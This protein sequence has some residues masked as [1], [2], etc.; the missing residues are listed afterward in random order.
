MVIYWDVLLAVNFILNGLILYLTAIGAGERVSGRRIV[1]AALLG[2]GYVVA[3]GIVE[4]LTLPI[5]KGLFSLILIVIAMGYRSWRTFFF[6]CG[7]FYLV[8]FAIGGAVL[9]WIGWGQDVLLGKRFITTGEMSIGVLLGAAALILCLRRMIVRSARRMQLLRVTVTCG[10]RTDTFTG[11]LDT[12]N[13]L[14]SPLRHTPVIIVE[15]TAVPSLVGQ[16]RD[17]LND[18]DEEEWVRSTSWQDDLWRTRCLILP[19]RTVAHSS[20]LIGIRADTVTIAMG[21]ERY[22]SQDAVIAIVKRTLSS[23]GTYHAIVPSRLLD[24]GE[25]EKGEMTWGA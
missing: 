2:A 3:G 8:S 25:C 9:G 18:S 1:I 10:D 19:Y 21:T 20:I 7:V 11:L 22:R 13:T 14:A 4:E 5:A 16:A 6:Y 17:Y 23:G 15:Y 12:G 24:E